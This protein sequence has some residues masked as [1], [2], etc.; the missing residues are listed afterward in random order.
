V[1]TG[2]HTQGFE[3]LLHFVRQLQSKRTRG[4]LLL[5]RGGLGL[6]REGFEVARQQVAGEALQRM[7]EEGEVHQVT[8]AGNV[9]SRCG[10]SP[11]LAKAVVASLVTNSCRPL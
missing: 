3:H 7:R 10:V 2:A 5:P 9:A 1:F 4:S 11:W 6:T 8:G